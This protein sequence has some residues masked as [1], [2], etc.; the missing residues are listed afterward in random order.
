MQRDGTWINADRRAQRLRP[1]FAAAGHARPTLDWLTDLAAAL[2]VAFTLPSAQTVRAEIERRLD[3][4]K[5]SGLAD[6][7]AAGRQL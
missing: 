4:F 2:G 5:G 7:G 6:L 3:T 1:A